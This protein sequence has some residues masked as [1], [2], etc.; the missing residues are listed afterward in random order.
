MWADGARRT[1]LRLTCAVFWLRRPALGRRL[2]ERA[3]LGELRSAGGK[4]QRL[5][6]LRW[7][8]TPAVACPY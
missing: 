5:L 8:A 2:L 4:M 1:R 6:E 7:N 3:A